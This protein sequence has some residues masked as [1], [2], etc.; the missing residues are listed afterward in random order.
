M[1]SDQTWW[2]II[3]WNKTHL[4]PSNIQSAII[5][6][7]HCMSMINV[8]MHTLW[9]IN[10][11]MT[12]IQY[13]PSPNGESGKKHNLQSWLDS[14]L[15]SISI[16]RNIVINL[17]KNIIPVTLRQYHTLVQYYDIQISNKVQQQH[18][19]Y[20]NKISQLDFDQ[21]S[22]TNKLNLSWPVYE[23]STAT[24]HQSIFLGW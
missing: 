6:W 2:W 11:N 7:A 12:I 10:T 9:S 20:S 22:F 15:T 1:F 14:N 3:K 5:I 18:C 19:K 24:N 4:S 16:H 17:I 8:L 21:W 23:P 13:R